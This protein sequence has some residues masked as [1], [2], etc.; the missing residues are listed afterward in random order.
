MA[1]ECQVCVERMTPSAAVACLV[2]DRQACKTCVR[3]YLL[4]PVEAQCMFC[5]HPWVR[6]GVRVWDP[7]H[8]DD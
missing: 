3:R 8:P 7:P 4:G 5:H 1:G 6:A 2:C